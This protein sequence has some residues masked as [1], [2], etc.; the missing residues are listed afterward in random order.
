MNFVFTAH[1]SRMLA[2]ATTARHTVTMTSKKT[3]LVL[4]LFLCI[5]AIT[6]SACKAEPSDLY[7]PIMN[8][9]EIEY[10]LEVYGLKNCK[11]FQ[12]MILNNTPEGDVIFAAMAHDFGLCT[13]QNLS[14]A[15]HFYEQ[16]WQGT[17]V[18]SLSRTRLAIIYE[19]GPNTIKKPEKAEFFRRDILLSEL[20]DNDEGI[21][22]YIR[23]NMMVIAP[24]PNSFKVELQHLRE[25]IKRPLEE[26][27]KIAHEYREQGHSPYYYLYQTFNNS[28]TAL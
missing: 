21:L 9:A 25:I 27:K 1:N 24:I 4:I 13:E 22:D 10:N 5:Q 18:D 17:I 3:P 6:I 23:P 19:F 20:D 11:A 2:S 26:R 8:E 14:K 12:M 7:F 16:F 15:A 28:E